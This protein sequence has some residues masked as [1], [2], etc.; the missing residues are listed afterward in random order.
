MELL[1]KNLIL[2]R[3]TNKVDLQR[4][5]YKIL[6]EPFKEYKNNQH[7]YNCQTHYSHCHLPVSD[8]N[9]DT[10]QKDCHDIYYHLKQ[11]A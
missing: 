11:L 4:E 2:L 10:N 3:D 5:L 1:E 7:T 8:K 9:E 6:G